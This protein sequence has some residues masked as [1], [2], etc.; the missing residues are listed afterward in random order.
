[1][2]QLALR[3]EGQTDLVS[4]L[5]LLY[6][7]ANEVGVDIEI[8]E[9]N[10]FTTGTS[11]EKHIRSTAKNCFD[12][13]PVDMVVYLGDQ[14]INKDYKVR[15]KCLDILR[16]LGSAYLDM[17][18]VG[19][20]D[21]NFEAWLLADENNFRKQLLIKNPEKPLRGTK[22]PKECLKIHWGEWETNERPLLTETKKILVETMNLDEAS[23]KSKDFKQFREDFHSKLKLIG[24][25][26]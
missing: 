13:N 11:I 15:T 22:D 5:S 7:L 14:D 23:R 18:V 10:I 4:I 2:I 25:S 24:K 26:K 16:E 12:I 3:H 8:L 9:T 19:I 20:A 6:R 1:M 21:R 17:S